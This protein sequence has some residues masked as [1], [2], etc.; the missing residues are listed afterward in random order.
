MNDSY[1]QHSGGFSK[2]ESQQLQAFVNSPEGREIIAKRL[3]KA[4][5]DVTYQ[6]AENLY[7]NNPSPLF[8]AK[9]IKL[10][11]IEVEPEIGKITPSPQ[12]KPDE[13]KAA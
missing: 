4:P 3:D 2:E 8:F 7:K 10:D 9:E 6:D 1:E 13:R 5:D 11:E 12:E